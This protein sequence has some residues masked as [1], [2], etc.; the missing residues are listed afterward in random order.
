MF[1][2]RGVAGH[3]GA[4]LYGFGTFAGDSGGG[5]V[6]ARHAANGRARG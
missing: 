1:M 2:D 3:A 5:I 6:A 4:D